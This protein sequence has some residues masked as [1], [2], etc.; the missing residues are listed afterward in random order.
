[1]CHF[2]TVSI[3]EKLVGISATAAPKNIGKFCSVVP[4]LSIG[5]TTHEIF[6]STC[7]H[8]NVRV[9]MAGLIVN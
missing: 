1:M 3:F 9:K 8:K 7:V 6:P 2:G 4:N 5:F